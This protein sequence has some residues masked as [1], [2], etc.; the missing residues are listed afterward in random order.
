MSNSLSKEE[1]KIT[2]IVC[3]IIECLSHQKGIIQTP[4]QELLFFSID[5]KHAEKKWGF[6]YLFFTK[7]KIQCRVQSRVNLLF[8]LLTTQGSCRQSA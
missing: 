6:Y 5:F 3:V 1:R 2:L 7:G 4:K 8:L